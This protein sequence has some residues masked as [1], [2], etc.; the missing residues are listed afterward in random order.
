M[1]RQIQFVMS[2]DDERKFVEFIF[3][4]EGSRILAYRHP[5]GSVV[6][7]G[8]SDIKFGDL[9]NLQLWIWRT[10]LSPEPTYNVFSKQKFRTI[11]SIKS[12]VIQ[13]TRSFERNGILK[14]GRL[15][16]D[17]NKETKG[18]DFIKWYEKLV[19]WVKKNA[20][21]SSDGHYVLEGASSWR[22]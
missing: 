19:R 9:G 5:M 3:S 14:P 6:Y 4:N 10:D 15:W 16:A 18:S 7:Y 21:L 12:E 1:G 17:L 8:E 13:F 2:N 22:K 11:N 20:V